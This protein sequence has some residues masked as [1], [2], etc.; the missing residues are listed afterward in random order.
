MA[1]VKLEDIRGNSHTD[2]NGGSKSTAPE[3]PKVSP[4]ID[5]SRLARD[6][7]TFGQKLLRTFIQDDIPDMK[8]WMIDEV[9]APGIKRLILDGL[10][11]M[12]FRETYS[13]SRRNTYEYGKTS[14]SNL[15]SQKTRS[16]PQKSRYVDESRDRIDYRN[17]VV[18]YRNDAESIVRYLHDT[19]A[20]YHKVS[21]GDL[22]SL[23]DILAN[24]N[25]FNWGWTDPRAIGIR[26][27]SNGFLIDVDAAVP[28]D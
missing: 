8:A 25:D 4:I 21:I 27:V 10:A 2:K 3:R 18:T 6:K 1:Q 23:V 22:Y 26:Q 12:F 9:I 15:Y 16:A 14:Y 28:I 17:I 7:K 20:E 19:I 11:M 24:P 13:G 5:K